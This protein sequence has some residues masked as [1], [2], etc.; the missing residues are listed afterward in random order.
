MPQSRLDDQ[1]P[2]RP[3]NR[4]PAVRGWDFPRS[5]VSALLLTRFAAEHGVTAEDVLHGS[6]LTPEALEKPETSITARQELAIVR[7]LISRV[8]DPGL[9]YR[10]GRRYHLTAYGVLGFAFTTSPTVR[11]GMRTALRYLELSF[12]FCTPRVR[13]DSDSVRIQLDDESIPVDARDF[14]VERD[15][16]GI[17]TIMLDLLPTPVPIRS[18]DLKISEPTHACDY[19]RDFGVMPAFGRT[20]NVITLDPG[21]LDHTLPHSCSRTACEHEC[22]E[23]LVRRPARQDLSRQVRDELRSEVGSS[24]E[25]VARRLHTSAR[26][27]HR[28]LRAEG[29]SFHGLRDELRAALAEEML[30][31]GVMSV[32]D[33]A[34][35]LGYSEAAS[36]IHAFKR[37]TGTTPAAFARRR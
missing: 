6:G 12:A 10:A 30:A 7:N 33:I 20:A 2:D 9:G 19:E 13:Q 5:P 24:M 16:A 28:K 34:I 21:H 8:A 32:E 26:T 29:N 27:L 23:R 37:W 1:Q 4:G 18:I 31:D 14:L 3:G 22:R 36:F 11:D 15:L 35:R 17:H 25:E